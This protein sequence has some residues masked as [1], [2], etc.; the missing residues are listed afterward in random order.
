MPSPTLT[1]VRTAYARIEAVDRPE[2][3]I[4][5]RPRADAEAEAE[6][7]DAR[8]AAGAHLPLAGRL[9]A[10]KGNIDVHGLPTTAGCPAYA[11]APDADAPVVARLRAA[12]AL[13]LG[14]TNLDQFATGLV[15]TRSPYGAVRG[16]HDPSR[17]SGGSSS[18]SAV[19][20]ALG[21]VDLA[22]GTDT[23]GSGRVPAAFNG[24]VGLKPTRGLVP[25]AGV[26]PACAS[27][28]CVTVFARTLPET[29]QALAHMS[30][31]PGRPLP[32][33]AARPPGPW[34][35]A[36]PPREQLGELDEGWAEA[37]ESAVSLL[38]AAGADVRPLDLTPFTEAAAMLYQGAFVAERYTAVGAFVDKALADGV[39]SL[40][41]TVAGIITRARDV[42]AHR[43]FA[44]QD[45]L[46]VLRAR[47]LAE[48]GDADALLL[49]TA[50]GH[51][52]LAEVAADPL[53]A[54]ARL[55]RFTNSTN[56]FDLAAVAVPAGEVNGLPFGV[57]LIGPAFTDDRL[58]RVAA[59]LRPEARL[60]VVG[61]HLSGQPLNPQL[62]SLGARLERTT[63]TAPVYRLHALRTTPPKPGLVHVGEGGAAVEAEIWRL[64]AEGLGRLLAALPRPMALGT[65]ELSDGTRVPG[66]LCEPAALRDAEDIT[67]YGGWRGYLSR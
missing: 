63:T 11:Y 26:V 32:P 29:E 25:T 47:A 20:V 48:L 17:I 65:V 6:A 66:F 2:I 50:P 58:A 37:Y 39:D 60:A 28:D 13:V 33:L 52:T 34:R 31:P 61:A 19:A 9:L 30:S 7:I 3:W 56:L 22:L 16:A 36:V 54:N 38:R 14:T 23:A 45:R 12:G 8:L 44:D 5:L 27:I 67:A 51:P 1:R 46:A 59:L 40:D 4:G 57:M 21:I 49:P 43:L 15:G 55:G 64:P 24:I 18:G 10:V 62:L 53:G 41:P 35:V 42:P